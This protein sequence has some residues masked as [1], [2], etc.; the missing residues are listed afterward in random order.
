MYK[1]MLS[2]L[3]KIGHCGLGPAG[4]PDQPQCRELRGYGRENGRQILR[5]DQG[6]NEYF[7]RCSR[8]SAG[9]V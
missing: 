4:L 2:M 3:S 5:S 6:G 7:S 8:L 9:A 1:T